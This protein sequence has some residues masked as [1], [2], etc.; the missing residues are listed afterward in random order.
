MTPFQTYELQGKEDFD[1]F[2][3]FVPSSQAWLS[4]HAS[5]NSLSA[6]KLD[7]LIKAHIVPGMVAYSTDL[8]VETTFVTSYAN[9]VAFSSG[10]FSS[11]NQTFTITTPDI[12]LSNGVMHVIDR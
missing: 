5:V 8:G 2:T 11:L 4:Q 6:S 7:D 3:V 1:N 10:L 9:T 12:P